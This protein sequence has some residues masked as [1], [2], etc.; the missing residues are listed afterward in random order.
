MGDFHKTTELPKTPGT[1]WVVSEERKWA[2][3]K[4]TYYFADCGFAKWDGTKWDSTEGWDH[5][6]GEAKAKSI[7]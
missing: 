5:W 6:Y 1:Y 2:E 4:Y 3:D 7:T